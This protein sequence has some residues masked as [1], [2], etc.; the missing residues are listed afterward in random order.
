MLDL[1]HTLIHSIMRRDILFDES[2]ER[3]TS[4]QL[5]N[6]AR[7]PY[8]RRRLVMRRLGGQKFLVKKRPYV[9]AFLAHMNRL[10]EMSVVTHG[11]NNYAK[12]IVAMLDPRGDLFGG[13]IMS[14]ERCPRSPEEG[15]RKT[16][17]TWFGEDELDYVIVVD[18]L[19]VVWKGHENNVVRI[20]RYRF[21]TEEFVTRDERALAKYM[22]QD[23]YDTSLL[24]LRLELARLHEKLFTTRGDDLLRSP[25]SVHINS[26]VSFGRTA[27]LETHAWGDAGRV[28]V[29][30]LASVAPMSMSEDA[31]GS[32]SI[33]LADIEADLMAAYA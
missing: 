2:V 27:E 32:L 1:D 14:R 33:A 10:F 29:A 12:S 3:F 6:D 16:L 7:D 25:M 8:W 5:I 21:F 20:P 4:S 30:S 17:S 18:D 23:L 24:E 13:R 31:V 22:R 9:D 15:L 26:R 19:K 28:T 11:T